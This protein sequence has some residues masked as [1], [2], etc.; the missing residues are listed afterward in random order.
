MTRFGITFEGR[1]NRSD[2]WLRGLSC[3]AAIS[4]LFYA[5]VASTVLGSELG[6]RP[7]LL[8]PPLA[9]LLADPVKAVAVA[10]LTSPWVAVIPGLLV[11]FGAWSALYGASCIVR[12]LHDL[13]RP[14]QEIGYVFIPFAGPLIL[15]ALYLLPGQP[16]RNRYGKAPV[17]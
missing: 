15:L 11:A 3:A 12:R 9:V 4:L 1:M 6:V 5:T 13:G 14:W 8:P 16:G 10:T 2:L 7:S 17:R